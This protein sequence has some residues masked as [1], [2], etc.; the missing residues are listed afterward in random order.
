MKDLEQLNNSENF[1]NDLEKEDKTPDLQE[2][3]PIDENNSIPPKEKK[4]LSQGQK[5]FL[6]FLFFILIFIIGFFIM[7]ITGSMVIPL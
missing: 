1:L 6:S 5:F 2:Q 3:F 7:L 4:K